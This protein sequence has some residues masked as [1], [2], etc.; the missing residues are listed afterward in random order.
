MYWL[1]VF[2]LFFIILWLLAC[3]PLCTINI[4]RE[5][6]YEAPFSRLHF[7]LFHPAVSL[8]MMSYN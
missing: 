5:L 6:N 8:D 1:V 7:E 4:N 3:L 2:I